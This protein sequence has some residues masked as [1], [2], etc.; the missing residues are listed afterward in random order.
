MK[1][2]EFYNVYPLIDK[3]IYVFQIEKQTLI[4]FDFIFNNVKFIETVAQNLLLDY[5]SL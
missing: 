5:V 2:K 3:T 1:G 4:W